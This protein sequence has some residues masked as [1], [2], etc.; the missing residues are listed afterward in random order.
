MNY[1]TSVFDVALA[2]SK[3]RGGS[4]TDE[5]MMDTLCFRQQGFAK[6]AWL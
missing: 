2:T 6:T 5:E 3:G 4:V 1:T